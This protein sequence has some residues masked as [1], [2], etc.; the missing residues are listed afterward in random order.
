MLMLFVLFGGL[1][2]TANAAVTV[3][4]SANTAGLS[5]T[6]ITTP[7]ISSGSTQLLL[8]GVSLRP[9]TVAVSSVTWRSLSCTNTTGSNSLSLVPNTIADE[10]SGGGD[11]NAMIWQFTSPKARTNGHICVTFSSAPD[12]AV[13][14]TTGFSGV[15]T[16]NPLPTH[17]NATSTTAT[18]ASLSVPSTTGN[19]I[20]GVLASHSSTSPTE[21]A[22]QTSQWNV[23]GTSPHPF[24]AAGSNEISTT[25]STTISWSGLTGT[26]SWAL[27]AVEIKAKVTGTL[28]VSPSTATTADVGQGISISVSGATGSPTYTWGT[29]GTCTGFNNPGSVTS[30]TFTPTGTTTNCVITVSDSTGDTSGQS[31][32]ITVSSQ[33]TVTITNPT[34]TEDAGQSTATFT[35]TNTPGAG[36]D[37]YQW[38]NTTSGAPIII[39][40]KTSTSLTITGGATGSFTYNVVITDSN[41]GHSSSNTGTLTVYTKPTVTIT[42]PT[43]AEGVGQSTATFTTTNTVG[44]GTD[45]YQWYN[46][47]SGA[48]IIISGKTSTSLT[49]TGGATGSFTYNV[50]I[51]D[52]NSGK[53]TSNTGTLTVSSQPTVTITNPTLTEDAGQ[54]TATF[55][56]TNTPGAGGDTYQWYNTTSGA[57]IIISGKTSTS[58]T[59]T[60][61]A[62][63]SFTYNVVITDSNNGHS[64]SN[65]GTLTVYTKP[66]VTITN[67]TLAEGVGQSTATFTTTNTVGSGT[68]TYQWYNTTSGAPIIISGKTSTS[69]TITGGATGSFTYNVVI[70]DSNSGKG[71]SNTGTLTVSS[72]PTVTITNP[73]LTEDA[74][75]STAT[76]T[77]TNT[78][79]AGGDTYQWYNTTSGAPIIISG[80]TS[81]SLTITGGATGSFTYNVVITDSNNGHSSSNT[82]TLTVYTKPTV[83]ITNPTLAEGVGQSTATFTTTNTVGSGTDTYQWYNTTSGAPII[84]SG[85]TSTSLTITGGA[86]GSFTYNV[87]ITDSNSGKG[88]SNTGTL[89]VSS[90][91]T[92]TITNPTLTEDAGQSTATFTTTN[93]PGAGGDTYQWYNTTSGAPIIISGKTSTSLTITGGATGSFTYNVVITDSNNGHS[94]S[95]KGTVTV[96]PTLTITAQPNTPTSINQGQNIPVNAVAS[97][98]SGS[99]SY[100]WTSSSCPG[101]AAS[102]SGNSNTY[103]STGTTTNCQFTFTVNDG[104]T[105]NTAS[106]GFITVS[107]QL[108]AGAPTASNT[109]IDI[110]QYTKLTAHELG[111]TAPYTY[112]WYS[113]IS[114]DSMSSSSGWITTGTN[115]VIT[116]TTIYIGGTGAV[117]L[118]ANSATSAE[119]TKKEANSIDL[120]K[121]N[122]DVYFWMYIADNQTLQSGDTTALELL[123]GSGYPNYNDYEC[124]IFNQPGSIIKSGWNQFVVPTSTCALQNNPP[125]N[126]VLN[127]ITTISLEVIFN[128]PTTNSVT[129]DDLG[130]SVGSDIIPGATSN[131]YTVSPTTSNTYTYQVTDSVGSVANSL[132]ALV[133]VNP[134]LSVSVSPSSSTAYV[135]GH[136]IKLTAEVT[137]GTSPLSY[138]WYNGTSIISGA[139]SAIYTENAGNTGTFGYNVVVTDNAPIRE[140]ATAGS[141]AITVVPQLVAGAPTVTNTAIDIGQSTTLT[142]K[143]SGGVSPYTYNWYSDPWNSWNPAYYGTLLDSMDSSSNWSTSNTFWPTGGTAFE[144]T[145]Q[146]VEGSGSVSLAISTSGLSPKNTGYDITAAMEKNVNINL[147]NANNFYFWV[148]VSNVVQLTPGGINLFL[149]NDNTWTNYFVCPVSIDN[150]QDG[151]NPI[152]IASSECQA[153][154]GSPTFSSNIMEMEFVASLNGTTSYSGS[155]VIVTFDNLRYNYAGGPFFNKA[156]VILTFDG[157]WNSTLVNAVPIMQPHKQTGVAYIVTNDIN[158]GTDQINSS[159]L[160]KLS[161]AGW[162]VASHTVNHANLVAETSDEYSSGIN[163]TYELN[164]S[165]VMLT[166]ND[167]LSKP[168]IFAYPNGAYNDIVIGEV[169]N[170]GYITARALD[171]DA[172]FNSLSV[173]SSISKPGCNQPNLYETNPGGL[174]SIPYNL[175]YRVRSVVMAPLINVADAEEYVNQ[176]VQEKGLLVLTFHIIQSALPGNAIDP[177]CFGALNYSQC[178]YYTTANF[179]AVSNYLYGKQLNGSLQVTNFSTYLA[180]MG[181]T[182]IPAGATATG[183]TLETLTVSPTSNTYYYYNVTDN[184]LPNVA[185]SA[186]YSPRVLV[187]VNPTLSV[188]IAPTS[189]TYIIGHQITL[190]ATVSGGTSTYTYNWLVYNSLGLVAN[191]LYTNSAQTTNT[192]S[193]ASLPIGTYYANVIV[194]DS[195]LTPETA[196][197]SSVVAVVPQLFAAAPTPTNSVIDTSQSIMLTSHPSGGVSPYTYNWYSVISWDSMSSSSGWSTTGTNVVTTNTTTG[198]Y[199]GG[200][201]AVTLTINGQPS[202]ELKKTEANSISLS[203]S[204]VYFWM[205]IADNQTLQHGNTIALELL[206]GSS[207][208]K[209]NDYQCNIFNEPGSIPGNILTVIKSGWNQFVVPTSLCKLQTITGDTNSVLTSINTI[210]FEPI[211][212]GLTTNSVTFDEL[213]YNVGNSIIPGAT[214]NTLTVSPTTS[215][216]YYYNVKDSANSVVISPLATITISQNALPTVSIAPAS[217]TKDVGQT[218]TLTA[219]VT[220]AGSGTDTFQWYN[221]TQANAISGATSN[222]YSAIAGATGTFTYNVVIT[223]SNGGTGQ[224]NIA[225]VNVNAL[226]TISITPS[227]ATIDAGQNVIFTNTVTP[228]TAPYLYS[229]TTTSP[230]AV[231][232]GNS[233]QFPTAGTYNVVEYVQDS[234]GANVPSEQVMI[235]VNALPTITL[236]PSTATIDAGQNVIFTNTVTPGTAPYL[237]S[238]TTN[239]VGAVITGNSIQFPT[240]GTY[241]VVEYVQDSTGANVP[242]EQAVITVNPQLAIILAPSTAT[243]DTGQNVIF[244]NTINPGTAPYLYSYTTN[245]VGAV[246]TGNSIQFP[247][248]GTYNVVEY[249]QDSTGA[250]VPS[251]QAVITVSATPTVSVLPLSQTE[252]VG[253]TITLTATAGNLGSGS[254]SYQWYNGT[255]PIPGATSLTYAAT[256][257]ATGTFNYNVVVTDSNFGTGT[258]ATATVTV[259]ATPTVSVLPLSQTED[260]GQTITLTATAGNLGSGSDSYQWYNGTTPIPGATSLTY[261]ATAG[262]TGTFN[263]NVVVTDSNF[264]TGT[265]AT[266]T[267]TV[268]ATPTVSVLPLSQTEDVGQTITLTATAG[269]LGSGS[270]SYQWYNGTTPIPGATSLTYAAT[271]GATGTFNYNV[272]VTDSNFGTGTSATATVTVSATPTVSVLPLSQTEDVGQTITLTATAGNLGSGSDSYQWYNGTTPIPGATSLTYAATAGATGTF[273]YNV[274]VTDSNFGTGTSATATVTV[275]ATPTVSVLPLSQTEDVGQTITLTATAGNLGS[276]SDSYQWYNGTTPIP[277]ATSLTYAATAGATGTFNYNVVVTD[278]N[279]GTGTSA[280]ATVTVSATPTVSVLPLSQTED[281]G[282]TITLTATAGNLGSGSD[283]YQWYNGTTPI[284]G[285][286]SLTYAA[287]AGA[288]GTFN[289]NVVVTDSNFG[290]GTSATATVTVSATPTVSVLPLSQTEDVGQTITLTATAGNLGSGSDSY[291]WYNGTTPIP[292]ATSLTYAATAGATGT[293]NY[294][295]VVTDSNFGTGTSATATVTV[296]ATPTVSVLPLSQTE[297]VGQTITLTATAGNLGSGSDSYQWYNGTTPIP[298][299]TSLT[300]AATAGATGTFNYNVVVTDSNFGTG[301]SATATVTVSA[302]PTVSVLPLSQTEDVGQTITLTAT[303]GNLGSGSD[304]YQWYNGTTP[305]PG[306]TSLTYAATAGATGTFNYNVVV[307]DSNFGTGTSATATVTVSATPTVSVLPLSQTEDVGQTITLTATAGNLGSGSDSYQWYNGTTPIPGATSLT[308]AATAGATGTFNYNVVVTD[309]NFGTGTSAT[310]T[311]TVSATPTVSVLPLSQTEDV[312]QTITLTATAGNLGSGSDSYQWYNG[313]TPIPGATSLTY[314]ATAGATG[315]FNYNV[316]VTD[317][318]FGTGTSA[319]ATVTVSAT[320]TVSVLPLSQTE[321]V[322]Q[323]ITLTAT[324]GNLGS[325]SDSYQWYNGTTPIPGATSLTYAATAGATGTFNYNVVV[326]DSNFGT[327]TSATATVTVSATPTVSVLPLSQTEDVGQT[328]TLTAT[329][330]NLGSG[331]DSYQWYN[332]TTPIPGATSLTYAATAGA[333]GTFNYNVVVT[334]SNFGTGTSATATVTVSATPTVSVLPLSQTEDVGQTITLTATAGNLGS[335][336]DSYQW[337]NGTTPIPGATSLTYAATAG[338]TGTFNYNVVVTDSNFGTG[339][340]A[341][342]TVT[343]SATPTVSVL[344]LSQTEDVGQTITLTATA[345][346]LGSGSDSYQWYNGTTPIPGATSLTYAATAG[347]TGT[348]NYNV[349]VTDSNF[350]TGTSATATVT[351]SATPTVSVLPLSQTEDVGQTITLTATAGNLGSGSDSYQWYNGTT[352]IPG[353]TSLTYAA[354]AGATGTFNYNVVVTDSNFG[355]GTSATAT[356]TVS[357]TPTVSV[358]PLSQ[359]E[360]VGQTI[361]LTAT[362]GNLGSGSDSYQWYNGT[363]PIPGATSLTYAATAGATGTFNYNVVVTDSNF[364]TGT[365]ATATVTVSATPTVSVLPLSQTEDV[366]QTITLTATAGNLGSGSDS[367]QWYNGTTPIPGATSLTYAATAGATGTFN[368]NVVV[369]DSNF[370]TGTSATATVTVSATPTVSVLPLSQTEDVG[371]TITLTAT[372]GNLGSGSDSYQWYNG[373]T[374]IPGATS[375]TYAATAGATGTFNYNVVVTDSNFGTGTSATATVT[376]SATPTVSV[377]PLSQTEDVGQ[378]ITL[379]ATAGNLGSGSDSYQWYNGTTPIPG[380]TSLT[381][382]ATAGATGT[383]N[384]NVVVTDSNF[385]TGTSAT[386]T[387]TV[388]AT[389]TSLSISITP[390]STSINAGQSVTFTN[391]TTGGTQ[392]YILF[393]YTT[394]AVDAV[395]TDNS[396]Q[397]PSAGNYFVTENVIDSIGNIGT[398]GQAAITVSTVSSPTSPSISITPS[399]TS[400]NAGQSVTF[401][402]ITTGGTTPYMFAYTTNAVDAVVT[403]NSIQFPTAGNYFVTEN[404][405]DSIGNIGTSG[406]VTITVSTVSS[407]TSPSISITPSS[408]SIN[409]GQSVTFTNITTGGTTPYNT[410]AYTTNAV[411]AVVTDNSIQFPT[412]GNYFVTENV[413]DSIGN[414]GTSGQ[415]TITVSTVSSPTSPSISITPSSTSINAGQSVTFTNITTGGTTPY[416][417]FAY[418]TNAVDAV[419]TDNSIQFPT[420]G[421]Y[422]VTENVIDSIGNI[423]T[424]GQA[425][426]T[427][428]TVSSPTSPSISITPSSTSI[429]AGQSVTFT[430]IT[431]GGTTPYNTFAYTTNAVDAVVTDNSIQ[432]PTA[433]NYFVTENVIDSIGNIGTSGQAAITVSTV[434]S[435]PT[436]GQL[437]PVDVSPT[438]TATA[439]QEL[440]VS[441]DIT[442][443][444]FSAPVF[445]WNTLG[446]C[447]DFINPADGMPVFNYQTTASG[448]TSNCVFTVSVSDAT[449]DTGS[450]QSSVV[451]VSNSIGQIVPIIIASPNMDV[452]Q[453]TMVSAD[454]S[455]DTF[456]SPQYAWA[457]SCPDFGSGPGDVS[458]FTYQANTATTGCVFNLVVSDS[459]GNKGTGQFGEVVV[460]ATPTVVITTG[461]STPISGSGETLTAMIT[462][463]TPPFTYTFYNAS[464]SPAAIG[465]CTSILSD[466]CSFTAF[467][468]NSN[469]GIT[470]DYTVAVVDNSLYA[471]NSLA[472]TITVLNTTL[473]VTAS[474]SGG[475][476]GS[477]GGGAGGGGGGSS[478]PLVGYSNSCASIINVAVPNSFSFTINGQQ[479]NVTDNF[480]GSNYTSVIVNGTTYVINLNSSVSVAPGVSMKLTSVSYIPFLHT[481]TFSA[482]QSSNQTSSLGVNLNFDN[483]TGG[484]T[485]NSVTPLSFIS[486]VTISSA[487]SNTPALP[488]GFTGIFIDNITVSN[489]AIKVLNLTVSYSCSIDGNTIAP[490]ILSKTDGL[491]TPITPFTVNAS[492]CTISFTIPADPIIA[493]LKPSKPVA[494]LAPPNSTVIT[495]QVPAIVIVPTTSPQSK[496]ISPYTKEAMS[497]VIILVGIMGLIGGIYTQRRIARKNSPTKARRWNNSRKAKGRSR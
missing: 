340:S 290:T 327:G 497:L 93:T 193:F 119:I 138:Q 218:I 442:G 316:V 395:I 35:T 96:N 173:F 389:P 469:S 211:F 30:F 156:Q 146:Y 386:A 236:I 112:N 10:L 407:P 5:T 44:S 255:T 179:T 129:F 140:T 445:T 367:Y 196:T 97:G 436:T 283:S 228:G 404:V 109:A 182:T 288:T 40:G 234:T 223:D 207:S 418:T 170:A 314:A 399:S 36:G 34:L 455:G 134:T 422:F 380:A 69:L 56:T 330:G 287:T 189:S 103:T 365:S 440:T 116:N 54:S 335:G 151:W 197:A 492:A 145:S 107:S 490:Y 366:G 483:V 195:A 20:F 428:S 168:T 38:Y 88:T 423:G 376:V 453:N 232:T 39:S 78:P 406:Q 105:T 209:Y 167:P 461:P 413:I 163:N 47:T 13:V 347:A 11:A 277:G 121:P 102:G 85:K 435:P 284:P 415:V 368:Y 393:A 359:T 398:S 60:G 331:S 32:T 23:F 293:F 153:D 267:V 216:T 9:S 42:N 319:T 460:N 306:A 100:T 206:L 199:I 308:Y 299:A 315:T 59:I 150:L 303:A 273:N 80:K 19:M 425:A 276:G 51:T 312:G 266:A 91:P 26:D 484:L 70:T 270:D 46:T 304:S 294:N 144:N 120:S 324:A 285:A 311:V 417:T 203:N 329:A 52:S 487:P 447:P 183:N 92:V 99:Y 8:V 243:I 387:V 76:F 363:T 155:N 198:F 162:D 470:F 181:N 240:A 71:T 175:S 362:A 338:A 180:E 375:L 202:A 360:D 235:T 101:S 229:Y 444:A 214:S 419:V 55:T 230:G 164:V 254:D 64:S 352:P 14:G 186:A 349:V 262:A 337:Y 279:F 257:G 289:Y 53:G 439:G 24:S 420:A 213:G 86:T 117:T 49:I 354:T 421:N 426:I 200:T 364:G 1:A 278:S 142:A 241:N 441:A 6:N 75:Q 154:G 106:T 33:P 291:Q 301:T 128:G 476:G 137:G 191:A 258:S 452:G 245:A 113:V 392:P 188:S 467:T 126:S 132:P 437:V 323:T 473:P 122:T 61:G 434:S 343:V 403:D 160:I 411:D 7:S 22:G 244:T 496:G 481:V 300:Y 295:V 336:S 4:F 74:G 493:L 408:T 66:T 73:T 148:Y 396:I 98:G 227:A 190:T 394:N 265:S 161:Q 356:V 135:V 355:T 50:V 438:N 249:V 133:T 221:G 89:T 81:T 451:T 346:N 95:N 369:T 358:L 251:E 147:G 378:T 114:W 310:A 412:A 15:D 480:I 298:G 205:Y 159:Q 405:I 143:A 486:G 217:Q 281:V 305:I 302:T 464:G 479:I 410:F 165:Q 79:G 457:S 124:D 454:I 82:G 136:L 374:P 448:E 166:A 215:N 67:P 172:I 242:S 123:L 466:T 384:Y 29:T 430:N 194:T 495:P 341:T 325:G 456:N 318:N 268:S 220:N 348:F 433:G 62:T 225:S 12:E 379:T 296:S 450:G 130:Y 397:F 231:I 208:P 458:S 41:N 414:I 383:F 250:N 334:D 110:G 429:N 339:T 332:G 169:K 357:A 108:V 328:I 3:V 224:S 482:C 345:G 401:T 274:V 353:A 115:V 432:F 385:G 446:S 320:P 87:V 68:D 400:I 286:T 219:T 48:P 25:S 350:G 292:G 226:P 253:Q 271:A 210:I 18:T 185:G 424:S 269:N 37:T 141:A 381:Y 149:S 90:Q 259:S 388:S 83:T 17:D 263:Y 471:F 125:P 485:V 462:G 84:I 252:D 494:P 65:T 468:S 478:V 28:I 111:G 275:S 377:L 272:V 16:T 247:T 409:A 222:T 27:S 264:G 158:D 371:Q 43:L 361:T 157:S 333:T 459:Y 176:A 63:G 391:I 2:H 246:I 322:G 402:N 118:E 21:G 390:S 344:P 212:N 233:I 297:D 321:D 72:Q 204:N 317:S 248:A 472:N 201:G 307:T 57:P 475:V 372:A 260:V 178:V 465:A 427:V 474:P 31:G 174:S 127:S 416:N 152:V 139:T 463:G 373:T 342:A 58:L 282:Q 239:A 477:S 431:T 489:N 45:T 77:T 131:T 187:T 309:S 94:S 351:V 237:Y 280:T 488:S 192:L 326:T 491:W 449:G 443:L 184:N 382:A 261:A 313:T 256:A 238:Y 171:C 104:L 370:G 177:A